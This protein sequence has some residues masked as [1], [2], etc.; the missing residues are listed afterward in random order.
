MRVLQHRAALDDLGPGTRNVGGVK[1]AQP[2]DFALDIV[3]QGRPVE[4]GPFDAPAEALGVGEFLREMA[5]VDEQFLRHAA[6]NDAG[7][8][9]PVLLRDRD[10]R[11]CTRRHARRTHAAGTA[12]DDEQII[13][14]WQSSLHSAGPGSSLRPHQ[15]MRRSCAGAQA[16]GRSAVRQP[17]FIQ[18]IQRP[19]RYSFTPRFCS[20]SRTF[21]S[22][23]RPIC[24]PQLLPSRI[25]SAASSGIAAMNFWPIGE[26]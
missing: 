17:R 24:C 10:A 3:A 2:G 11:A 21:C 16:T 20:S 22:A 25:A 19:V 9:D 4:R 15:L 12:A 18:R 5:G 14:E 6:A 1:A 26:R 13:V 23:S 7:A 8:A